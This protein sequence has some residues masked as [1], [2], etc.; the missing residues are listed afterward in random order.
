MN[1]SYIDF[2]PPF[3][4]NIS[5]EL[6]DMLFSELKMWWIITLFL[7]EPGGMF[8]EFGMWKAGNF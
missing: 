4:L 6:F 1:A 3:V 7:H 5:T 8:W 2:S